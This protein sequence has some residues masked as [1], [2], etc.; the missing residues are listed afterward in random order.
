MPIDSLLVALLF[1][2]IFL[3]GSRV[4]PLASRRAALSIGAGVSAAYVFIYMLPELSEAGHTF[5]ELTAD[6][7][8]PAPE[9]R[10]Y[11]SALI[12]FICFYGLEH[13]V[14]W[15][16]HHSADAGAPVPA[17]PAG[18]VTALQFT[19]FAVYV[20]L[21]GYLLV[22]SVTDHEQQLALYGFAMGLHFLGVERTLRREHPVAFESVGRYVLAAA[23]VGGWGIAALTEFSQTIVITALGFVSGGVVMNS[24]V[25]ELPGEAD[26]RFWPFVL[27]A[28]SYALLLILLL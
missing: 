23:A 12:G 18:P 17:E 16:R 24:M 20:G 26:G 8:L 28:V 4:R 7:A 10:V 1:A 22:H 6:R 19:G 2:A 11:L 15:S 14:G 13:L 5:V 27:G 3:G 9:Y 25:M 21:V